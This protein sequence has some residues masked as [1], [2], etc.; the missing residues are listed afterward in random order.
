MKHIELKALCEPVR[1]AKK[2][3][4]DKSL[5]ADVERKGADDFV[6]LADKG[7]QAY[8]QG[9]L[10]RLYPDCKFMGEEEDEHIIDPDTPTFILDPIDG[11]TNFIH[12]F[13][14]SAVSLALAHKGE[15]LMGVI[16]NPFTDEMFYA[17]RGCG[18]YCNGERIAVS[19]IDDFSEA[20]A[21]IGTAP[22][23]KVKTEA[24]FKL[25]HKIFMEAVDFRRAGSAAL[26]GSFTAAGRLECY[27]EYGLRPWDFSAAIVICEEAGGKVTDWDGERIDI[28]KDYTNVLFSNGKLHEVLLA[29]IKE[30][31]I[32]Y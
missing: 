16:Y 12:D 25:Y 5:S 29:M 20:L 2:I 15:I 14:M 32:Q 7:V 8:I 30:S 13:K 1:S 26:D 11:T 19:E 6:T 3:I 4:F 21:G 31:G 10:L 22:Y 23:H 24:Y 28:S 17:E 9:E 27:L 18:A